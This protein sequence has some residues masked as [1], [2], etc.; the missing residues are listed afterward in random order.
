M[1]Q[2]P[3]VNPA[4][5]ALGKISLVKLLP[6]A[7]E[8]WEATCCTLR[9]TKPLKKTSWGTVARFRNA[10]LSYYP[11]FSMGHQLSLTFYGPLPPLI[12][13]D[14]LDLSVFIMDN[15]GLDVSATALQLFMPTPELLV[16]KTASTM[17][18]KLDTLQEQFPNT[19]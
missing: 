6:H 9:S 12:A 16:F 14:A 13:N 3:N 15:L 7:G 18:S 17:L 8:R 10:K 19:P 4:I 2:Y 5:Q 11:R 1:I